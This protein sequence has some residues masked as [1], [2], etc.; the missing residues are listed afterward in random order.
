M[1][2][3][4]VGIRALWR[5]EARIGTKVVHVVNVNMVWRTVTI[6]HLFFCGGMDAMHKCLEGGNKQMKE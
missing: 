3:H 4:V 5:N 1:I 6:I 2:G